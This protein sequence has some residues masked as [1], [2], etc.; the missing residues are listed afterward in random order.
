MSFPYLL[1]ECIF[2][3]YSF[4]SFLNHTSFIDIFSFYNFWGMCTNEFV[5]YLLNYIKFTQVS[6]KIIL[7]LIIL[8]EFKVVVNYLYHALCKTNNKLC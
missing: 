6:T 1:I 5:N 8:K 2:Y 4:N 3:D 7:Y